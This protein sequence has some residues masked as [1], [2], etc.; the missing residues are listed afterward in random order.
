MADRG[1]VG[2][3]VVSSKACA[4]KVLHREHEGHR[5]RIKKVK[6]STDM[7]TP[8]VC[9]LDCHRNNLKKERLLEDRYDEIDRENKVLLKKMADIMKKPSNYNA[10]VNTPLPLSLNG[11][12]R[13][14]QLQEITREN[15]RILKSIQ[16]VQPVYRTQAWEASY[17]HTEKLLKN[18]CSY[19][20]VVR[21]VARS[22]SSPS[23]LVPL[24]PEYDT[25]EPGPNDPQPV[26]K[27]SKRFGDSFWLVDMS[28]D[29][30]VLNISAYNADTEMTLELIVNER[31]HRLLARQFLGDYTEIASRLRIDTG[32]LVLETADGGTVEGGLAGS[33][34]GGRP[35]SSGV[36]AAAAPGAG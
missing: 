32:R 23:I 26:L 27:Q 14:K 30:R 13:K 2:G 31:T 28:T 6:P 4:R 12:G 7:S 21:N 34:G 29:G 33:G 19:P 10:T 22:R 17:K 1:R 9:T 8:V 5:H 15:Q 35:A 25:G 36:A 24:P 11:Q 20:V 3:L 18:C 16:E